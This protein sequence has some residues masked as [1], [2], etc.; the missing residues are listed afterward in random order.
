MQR[1][2]GKALFFQEFIP[3][4]S[5][6]TQLLYDMVKKDFNWD[7]KTWKEDYMADFDIVK[8]C[9]ANS[10]EKYFPDYELNWILRCD[11]S[12]P[13]VGVVLLQI[14]II[15]DKE[16]YHPIGFKSQKFSGAA[17]NWDM[18]K[19]EAYALYFGMKSLAYYLRGKAFVVETDH[20]NLIWIERSEVPIIVWWRVYMQSFVH[21]L[22][23]IKGKQ[24]I[25]ADWASRLYAMLE[26]V[27]DSLPLQDIS[28]QDEFGHELRNVIHEGCSSR[29]DSNNKESQISVIDAEA[30]TVLND[31]GGRTLVRG[32]HRRLRRHLVAS[33]AGQSSFQ[34]TV[35]LMFT[36]I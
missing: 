8:L 32:Y 23:H 16:V 31:I 6:E 15:D 5:R 3:N 34:L 21:V 33:T 12:E 13:A 2:L 35:S 19:K 9:L 26:R 14:M 29:G 27:F 18:H 7:P 36:I 24:N 30:D 4:Y 11:A 17:L 25:V 1:F 22:I 28:Q 10:T 20:Q